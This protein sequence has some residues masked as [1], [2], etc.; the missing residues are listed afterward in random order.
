VLSA[1]VNFLD[2]CVGSKVEETCK[3][4]QGGEVFVASSRIFEMG[5]KSEQDPSGESALPY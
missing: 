4:A 1:K 5:L 2:D 3:A